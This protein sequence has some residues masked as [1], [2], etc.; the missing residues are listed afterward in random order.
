MTFIFNNSLQI[1]EVDFPVSIIWWII[2]GIVAFL[3]LTKTQIGNWI[4][5]TGAAKETAE[6]MGVPT[7]KVKISLFILTAFCAWFIAMTQTINLWWSRCFE[8]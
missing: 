4:F 1:G 2:L 3:L 5:A 6:L 7:H 8:R